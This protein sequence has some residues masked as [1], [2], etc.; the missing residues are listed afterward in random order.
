MIDFEP[1]CDTLRANGWSISISELP[2]DCW[3]AKDIWRLESTWS[4]TD[5]HVFM[6]FLLDP[7]SDHDRNNPPDTNIWAVGISSLM[8]TERLFNFYDTIPVRTS[9]S[10]AIPN[11]V[12]QTEYLRSNQS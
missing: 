7:I 1:L 10:R 2:C 6:T 3:W 12:K 4:P 9:F 8:P 11:I 5:S